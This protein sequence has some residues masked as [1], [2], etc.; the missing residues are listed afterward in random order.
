[1]TILASTK[2][3]HCDDTD[4]NLHSMKREALGG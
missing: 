2:V 1:M 3:E 4:M